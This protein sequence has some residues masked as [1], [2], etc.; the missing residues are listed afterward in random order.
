MKILLVTPPGNP[1]V[2]GGDDVFVYEPLGLE[3]LAGAVRSEHDVQIRDM[4]MEKGVT[5]ETI[6]EQEKP[7]LIGLTADS[8]DVP[9][10]LDYS[11]K[12]K[13]FNKDTFVVVGGHHGTF[14]PFDFHDP[15]HIDGVVLGE[16]VSQFKE[17]VRCVEQGRGWMEIP[18]MAYPTEQGQVLSVK[19][20]RADLDTYLAP[21]RD[22]VG[23]HRP[24]YHDKLM[25]P[26]AS[27]R[28]TVGCP[29]RC[30]FC[31]LWPFTDGHYLKRH[32]EQV[33][34]EII[35]LNE[36]N[37]FLTDD[38][39]LVDA[40]RMTDFVELIEQSGIQ[41]KYFMYMRSDS[42]MRNVAL[43]ERW[44]AVGLSLALVGFESFM[45]SDLQDY[46]KANT[47]KNN[48]DAIQ[49]LHR[50]G[51]NI[52]AQIVI[53][54]DYDR[55]DFE[56][57][58]RFV[59][60][61]ELKTPTFTIL[62]PLPGTPLF[63]KMDRED[64]LIS[65]NW[66]HYDLMHAVVPTKLPLEEFYTEFF[67]LPHE[68]YIQSVVAAREEK[69]LAEKLVQVRKFRAVLKAQQ[70]KRKELEAQGKSVDIEFPTVAVPEGPE[71]QEAMR[72]ESQY[73]AS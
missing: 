62:T 26:I 10:V 66:G 2:I 73:V 44:A 11:R 22:L 3:Y 63:D 69:P 59:E 23:Q 55:D 71:A 24:E 46:N 32:L 42:I 67:R 61:M 41:K 16:G 7:D 48:R 68:Q 31:S 30:N 20:P 64:K 13:R 65:R 1:E 21:A 29:Y 6:L 57:V 14:R 49:L 45:E 50:L 19:A 25:K 17:L 35:D 8:P 18:G 47:V 12:A 56:R 9:T 51:V 43:V 70:K 36:P 58:K 54:P 53:R 40:R 37:I 38:E 52:A 5:F 34:Q 33:V 27:I 72:G 28:S 15:E 39:A 60:E 4:R